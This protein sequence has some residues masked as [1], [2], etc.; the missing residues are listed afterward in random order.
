MSSSSP[1]WAPPPGVRVISFEEIHFPSEHH[2]LGVG[3]SC[4]VRLA[5][6]NN[7]DVAVKTVLNSDLAKQ[8]I[9]M[10]TNIGPHPNIITMLGACYRD[11]LYYIILQW[12]HRGSLAQLITKGPLS[13][14]LITLISLDICKSLAFLHSQNIIHRDVKPSNFLI[15]SL[16]E[17]PYDIRAKLCD[18]GISK[19]QEANSMTLEIGTVAYVAPERYS[20]RDY[21]S[22]VDVFSFGV[23]LWEL[24]SRQPPFHDVINR[25]AIMVKITFFWR[26]TSSIITIL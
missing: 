15:S 16:S 19:E 6:W 10:I 5:K 18:F 2:I 26:A 22:K 11:P 1:S 12:A 25:S 21:S 20:S 14:T 7:L 24:F 3:A 4:N 13:T 9:K 17:D 23:M 8:E